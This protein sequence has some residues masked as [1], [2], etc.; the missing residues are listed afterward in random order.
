MMSVW[1]FSESPVVDGNKLLCTPVAADAGMVTLDKASG[2][3]I[4]RC[5]L[6]E[7]GPAGKDG[8]G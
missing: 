2:D 8:A 6:P 7:V 5:A 3:E 1:K 4:W